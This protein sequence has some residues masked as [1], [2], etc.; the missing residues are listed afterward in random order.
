MLTH[1]AT[2]SGGTLS[3]SPSECVPHQLTHFISRR[4]LYLVPVWLGVSLLSFSLS[5]LAPG[6]PAELM[7]VRQT[8]QAPSAEEV[9]RL[10]EELGLNGHV[11]VRYA[12]WLRGVAAGDLGTSYRT[13]APVLQLL[14]SRFPSTLQL[15][16]SAMLLGVLIAI[17]LGAVAAINRDSITDH[18]ARFVALV[19]ASVPGFLVG[20]LLILFFAVTLRILPV[21]GS[22][23][24]RYLILPV[25]TLA[26]G[27]AAALVRLTRANMLEVLGEDY[28]RTARAKG[29]GRR[30]VYVR[31]ALRN[32]LNPIVTLSGVRFGRLLGGAAIVETIFG[33]PGIGKTVVEAIQDRDYPVIQGF[34]LFAGTVFLLANLLV[35]ISYPWLDPRVRLDADLRK[36]RAPS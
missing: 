6:D 21:A 24:W 18:L 29:A 3:G 20:Y 12:R 36:Y 28:V 9:A 4:L 8:G 30:R 22:D 14:T 26:I 25:F 35:D 16:L 5:N 23:G 11:A 10:R 31:H 19:G 1:P 15:A 2:I 17:P 7:L 34:I 27:E 32:A 33:R 13:G